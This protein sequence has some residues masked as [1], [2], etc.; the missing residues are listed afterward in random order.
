[1]TTEKFLEDNKLHSRFKHF[2]FPDKSAITEC[3]LET[4]EKKI[5]SIGLAV[6][7]HKDNFCKRRGRNDSLQRAMA[8]VNCKANLPCFSFVDPNKNQAARAT[9]KVSKA[10]F[11]EIPMKSDSLGEIFYK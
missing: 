7:S 6:C 2:R 9:H 11:Y 4:E 1:M 10:L 8:S 3:W 5:V